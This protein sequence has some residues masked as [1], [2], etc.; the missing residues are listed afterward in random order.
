MGETYK[1]KGLADRLGVSVITV[2]NWEKKGLIPKA[3]RSVFNWR[4][5]SEEDAARIERLVKEKHYF[6]NK[7]GNEKDE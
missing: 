5:H 3:K 2:K 7:T 6:V 4:E 1:I